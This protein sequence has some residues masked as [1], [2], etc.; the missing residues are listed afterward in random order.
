MDDLGLPIY[1]NLET[2]GNP[3]YQ[4][5]HFFKL[6]KYSIVFSQPAQ[7]LLA[8]GLKIYEGFVSGTS[9][10]VRENHGNPW[11]LN[12]RPDLRPLE[13]E[14]LMAIKIYQGKNRKEMAIEI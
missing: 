1:G 9:D 11:V 2:S 8:M 4:C 6:D 12:C 5:S 10:G 14:I 3:P 13:N 7:P